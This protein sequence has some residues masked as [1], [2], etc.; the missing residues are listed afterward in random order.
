MAFQRDELGVIELKISEQYYLFKAVAKETRPLFVERNSGQVSIIENDRANEILKSS[1][2]NKI[3]YGILGSIT[4]LA[5]RYLIVISDR[6]WIGKIQNSSIFTITKAEIFRVPKDINHLS[7][8]EKQDEEVYLKMLEYV[9]QS[10]SFYFSYD[11]DLTNSAQR[12]HALFA[13]NKSEYHFEN[14]D[15]RFF[16][17]KNLLQD[18]LPFNKEYTNWILPV[19]YGYLT[20]ETIN[21]NEKNLITSLFRA[22]HGFVLE[23]ATMLGDWIDSGIVRIL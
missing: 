23:R 14:V 17:N 18:L 19:I 16:W 9:I 5:G 8:L 13:V 2:Q 6:H 7:A 10:Q 4:L 15:D 3:I 21:I 20:I 11:Y 12:T 1:H 22:G